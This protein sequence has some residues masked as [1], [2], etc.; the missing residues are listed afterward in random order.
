MK[1]SALKK[2]LKDVIARKSETLQGLSGSDNPSVTRT[3]DR[4]YGEI[5]FPLEYLNS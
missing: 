2:I 5:E 1:T 4:L 3:Y